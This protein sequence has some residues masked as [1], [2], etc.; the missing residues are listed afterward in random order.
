M[1]KKRT[2]FL[3]QHMYNSK[4]TNLHYSVLQI[5]EACMFN[6]K[7]FFLFADYVPYPPLF[8]PKVVFVD[9]SFGNDEKFNVSKHLVVGMQGRE[10]VIKRCVLCFKAMFTCPSI[11]LFN[12]TANINFHSL[13]KFA[14]Y[15]VTDTLFLTAPRPDWKV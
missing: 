6:F 15:N 11:Y 12:R 1:D 3:D 8:I 10:M 7:F 9:N 2:F 13:A 4:K 14:T 5:Y